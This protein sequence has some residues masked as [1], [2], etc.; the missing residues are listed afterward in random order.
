MT[1]DNQLV[2]PY[3]GDAVH[4]SPPFTETYNHLPPC[5]AAVVTAV[6]SQGRRC[7]SIVA[8]GGATWETFVPQGKPRQDSTWHMP[9]TPECL[10][11]LEA[12]ATAH[13]S[14]FGHAP[15]D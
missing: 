15:D 10:A 5:K 4:Y 2:P 8:V 14:R 11:A 9:N 6:Q 7:L 1:T 13:G 12:W 3:I